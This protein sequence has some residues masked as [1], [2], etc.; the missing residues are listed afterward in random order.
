MEKNNFNIRHKT[1][2]LVLH[3]IKPVNGGLT[4]SV[5][6]RADALASIVNKVVV[7][8]FGFDFEY[9]ESV[10]YWKDKLDNFDKIEFINLFEKNNVIKQDIEATRL[11][12][13]DSKIPDKNNPY[14][15]RVFT[16]GVYSRYEVYTGSG[17]L[18][19]IDHFEAPWTRVSKSVFSKTGAHIVEHYMDKQTNKL[20]FSAYFTSEGMPIYSC[21]Y[22]KETGKANLFFEHQNAIETDDFNNMLALWLKD[23]ANR[24][25][26]PVLFLDK[27]EFVGCCANLDIPKVFVLHNPH[28][29][30]PCD[31]FSKIDLS[32][33][34][35]LD[36]VSKLDKFV[37]LT[38]L[39]KEHLIPI[40]GE[41]SHKLVVINHAQ[42]S[43]PEEEKQLEDFHNYIVSS[44]ARY[45]PQKNLFDAI[46]AFKLVATILPE[47]I[48]NIYGYGPQEDELK[49][50][51]KELGL[52]KNVFL[53]GFT[54]NIT[55]VYKNSCITILTS[56]YEG[57][58][59]V[60][61]ESMSYGVPVISYDIT[62]GPSEL[63]KDGWNGFLIKKYDIN[64]LAEKILSVLL[65][66]DLRKTLSNN[67]RNI[68][69]ELSLDKFKNN[70]I[71][72]L[73]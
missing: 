59:L 31:D 11:H 45:H 33:K 22:D 63:I 44:I 69:Q 13:G 60:I 54:K 67:A 57:Q 55:E 27:R 65:D 25:K 14:A 23:L 66:K 73:G 71:S 10:S 28:L 7:F 52:E 47:A 43:L 12:K 29:A 26:N 24:N 30:S 37:V 64:A 70:W 39:Q 6:M 17:Y 3:N 5:M 42:K 40:L 20:S 51:I 4:Y 56:R 2:I 46:K 34:P 58:P 62:Y 41:H 9:Q 1:P 15:Y 49:K 21:K 48:Y 72:V 61:G 8:T 68:T 18:N 36:N 38:Q 35:V 32:M 19:S 50:L 53:K 16:S